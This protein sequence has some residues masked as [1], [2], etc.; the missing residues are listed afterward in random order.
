MEALAGGPLPDAFSPLV[1]KD[2]KTSPYSILRNSQEIDVT[3]TINQMQD[4]AIAAKHGGQRTTR[5]ELL[6]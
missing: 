1:N 2:F 5:T 3:N 4:M 6:R